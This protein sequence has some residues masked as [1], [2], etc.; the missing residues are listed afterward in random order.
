[1][2]YASVA[3]TE[4][5]EERQARRSD[6]APHVPQRRPTLVF[7]HSQRSGR[8]RLADG[9][10][11]QVLQRRHNHDTFTLHR[12]DVERRRDL[13][14][15]FHVEGVPTILVLEERR[16]RDRAVPPALAALDAERGG[17]RR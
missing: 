16:M 10:L 4:A 15:R 2:R 12:V 5:I 7:F 1:M 9:Y 13:A 3:M 8:C 6:A 11:A 17:D 14:R